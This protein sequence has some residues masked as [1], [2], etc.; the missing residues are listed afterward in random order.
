LALLSDSGPW[1]IPKSSMWPVA[2]L[3]TCPDFISCGLSYT[4]IYTSRFITHPSV[5]VNILHLAGLGA[6]PSGLDDLGNI[7]S[8]ASLHSPDNIPHL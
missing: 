5:D 3:N 2:R 8:M 6:F 1:E 4:I 7:V